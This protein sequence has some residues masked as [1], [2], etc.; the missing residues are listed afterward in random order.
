MEEGEKNTEQIEKSTENIETSD[1]IHSFK[2]AKASLFTPRLLIVFIVV[3]FLGI[4]SGYLL[5]KNSSNTPISATSQGSNSSSISKGAVFGSDDMKTFKDIAEGELA[6]GGIDG[7][8]Q[9][10]LV[11]PGGES[12]NVYV[13]SS[14]VDLSKFVG[15][16]LKVWGETQ[17]AQHAGWLMD[18]G[19]VE[20]L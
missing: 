6:E 7:E 4:G 10:H 1:L 8:G 3:I 2:D 9:F 12:Q 15:K 13:T 14:I 16:K 20:V 18:V 17:K 11:R 19:K 5:S